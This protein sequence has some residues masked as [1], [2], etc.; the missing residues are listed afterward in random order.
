MH[1]PHGGI[2]SCDEFSLEITARVRRRPMCECA[3]DVSAAVTF[4]EGFSS[5]DMS[6]VVLHPL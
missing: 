5:D 6:R 3:E 4:K 2:S 1:I